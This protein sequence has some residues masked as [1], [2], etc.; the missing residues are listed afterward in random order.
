MTIRDLIESWRGEAS[1]LRE[2]YGEERLARLCE[3]HA[4][5]LEDALTAQLDEKLPIQVA[6]AESG[7]SASQLRRLFGNGPIRRRE[8]PR[9][10]R[11]RSP[12]MVVGIQE[13]RAGASSGVSTE[14][15]T[16]SDD[17]R[18]ALDRRFG[19]QTG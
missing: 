17:V 12:A 6:A 8:L 4:A 3:V 7:Y 16:A 14:E 15:A 5:E 10:A 19:R 1:R 11:A 2:R 13:I 18:A 9:K